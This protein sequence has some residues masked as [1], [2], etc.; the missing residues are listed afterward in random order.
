VSLPVGSSAAQIVNTDSLVFNK[1]I[2]F[3]TFQLSATTGSCND[4]GQAYF[5]RL[6]YLTGEST[7]TN[8]DGTVAANESAGEGVEVASTPIIYQDTNIYVVTATDNTSV[9]NVG[10]GN[11]PAAQIKTWKEE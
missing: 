8:P 2:F 1:Q 11:P 7:Y 10:G 6:N 3:N 9:K 5:Y 4:I